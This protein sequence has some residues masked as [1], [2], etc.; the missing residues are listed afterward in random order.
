MKKRN[1]LIVMLVA[2][3]AFTLGMGT[4]A[5]YTKT[6]SSN[7]NLVRAAKFEVDSNGTLDSNV[8]FN[9]DRE[10]IYP[11]RNIDVYEFQIDKKGTEVPVKYNITVTGNDP[12]FEGNSPVA[13]TV[14]RKVGDIWTEFTGP[15]LTNPEALEMFKINLF[16]DHTDHDIDYQGKTGKI[17]INVVATQVDKEAPPVDP[18]D[19][20]DPEPTLTAT[21]YK[22]APPGFEW[23][24]FI[25]L[26]VENVENAAK[27]RIRYTNAKGLRVTTNTYNLEPDR[28]KIQLTGDLIDPTDLEV[29]V[30]DQRGPSDQFGSYQPLHTF[31][32]V[33]PTLVN[34]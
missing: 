23:G 3:L 7:D 8:E 13:L 33:N 19:P 12:L 30:Y 24:T 16:W 2:V 9:L 29:L 5:Y 32:N 22:K 25:T 34:P 18:V 31:Y 26:K 4:L 21:Y 17:N 14:L 10:P 1:L 20:V 28:T 6:F 15:E 11:G 27:F